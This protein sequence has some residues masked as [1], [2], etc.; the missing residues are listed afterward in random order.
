MYNVIRLSLDPLSARGR[1]PGS[2]FF[3]LTGCST[4]DNFAGGDKIDYRAAKTKATPASTCR[5][6]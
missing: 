4:L 3:S 2:G 6:I 5:P 1:W